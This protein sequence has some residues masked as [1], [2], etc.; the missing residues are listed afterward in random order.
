MENNQFEKT[1]VVDIDGTIFKFKFEDYIQNQWGA[2][3]K[4]AKKTL[5]NIHKDY[6]IVLFT[7]RGDDER[8]ALELHL[9]K[10]DIPYDELRM[11]KPYADYYID[12]RGLR[13]NNWND[14]K[15]EVL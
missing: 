2:P 10:Y 12:D 5:E 11:N 1:V 6:K 3:I 9:R 8:K 7:A 14:I 13:F 4:G 15:R